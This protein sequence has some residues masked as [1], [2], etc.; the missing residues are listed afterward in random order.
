MDI[1][2]FCATNDPRSYLHKPMRHDGYLYATNCHIAVRIAY[3]TAAQSARQIR[4]L[5][6]EESVE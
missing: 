3:G 1:T 6:G 4:A 5:L 2:K